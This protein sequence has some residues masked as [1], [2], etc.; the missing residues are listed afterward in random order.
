[1]RLSAKIGGVAA[2]AAVLLAGALAVPAHAA[3]PS[4]SRYSARIAYSAGGVPH[5][6]ARDFGGAGYG[7]GYAAARD[8]LCVLADDY[9]TLSGER[10]RFHGAAASYTS[11]GAG[12][13]INN[14]DSDVYYRY[15]DG[16]GVIDRALASPAPRGPRPE[17]RRLVDGYVAGYNRYVRDVGARTSDPACRGRAWVRPITARLVYLRGLQV[18][19]LGSG[20]YAMH[21]LATAAPPAGTAGRTA[22]TAQ[23]AE[24]A[25]RISAARDREVMGSNGIAIGSAGVRAGSAARGLLYGNPHMPWTGSERF[26]QA[27]L[28]VPGK[29]DISGAGLLGMPLTLFGH[30]N[31]MAW[32]HTISTASRYVPMALRLAP[33]DPTSYV[34]DG[35]REKMARRTITVPAR[36]DDGSAAPVRRTVWTTRYGPVI[37]GIQGI[38]LPWSRGTAYALFDPNAGGIRLMNSWF[39]IDRAQSVADIRAALT[40]DQGIPSSNTLAVD[41]TGRAFY[42]DVSVVPGVT[43][44]LAARCDTKLGKTLWAASSIPVLDASR[45]SCAPVTGK[46]ALQ[47]GTFGPAQQPQLTRRD[48][49]TNSNDS[50]WLTNPAHP[51][52]GYPRMLGEAGTV[53]SPRTRAGLVAVARR[54]A[55]T[56][57]LPG[58]GFDRALLQEVGLSDRSLAGELTAAD[59]ARMCRALP[60]GTAPSAGGPVDVS[61]ACGVLANWDHRFDLDS[62]GAVLFAKFWTLASKAA[63]GPWKVPFTAADPVRTPNTLATGN[64]GVRQALGEAVAAMRKAGLPLDATPRGTQFAE[65]AGARIPVPGGPSAAGVLNALGGTTGAD[66]TT[67]VGFGSSYIQAVALAP[68]RCADARTVLTYSQSSDPTS[69]HAADQT[70]WFSG[71]RLEP[72]RSCA[73]VPGGREIGG[74]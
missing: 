18:G 21:G 47:P 62:R 40:G 50:F 59:A 3:P 51:M 43:D 35:R 19:I 9:L 70:R 63:G 28:T 2:G 13:S 7:Y 31:G 61:A 49:V 74:S 71:K 64:P 69:P 6:T 8:N 1:M 45:G 73:P 36:A 20:V 67:A 39:D 16:S 65:P 25:A 22:R 30:T 27:Q 23:A 54:L 58:R 17:L 44:A 37:T 48:Y 24:A 41:T 32:T 34:V 46:G 29:L 11:S 57:G 56:D 14:L 12:I 55:G 52:T 42:A 10:S 38:D 72:D 68:G 15:L 5:I 60:D 66:G 26:W 53:R 4:E 33:G